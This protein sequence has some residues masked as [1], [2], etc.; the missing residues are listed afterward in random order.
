MKLLRSIYYRLLIVRLALRWVRKLNPGDIVIHEGRRWTLIQGKCAPLWD[1]HDGDDYK[2]MVHERDF[3][4]VGGVRAAWRSFRS[5]YDFYMRSW[6]DIWVNEGI[7]PW[8]RGC[9]IWGR[10][11]DETNGADHG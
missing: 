2:P 6:H 9:N 11:N 5:G 10:R 1:L 4:K 3:R 7:K 8:M